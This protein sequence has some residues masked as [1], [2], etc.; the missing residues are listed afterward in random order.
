MGAEQSTPVNE[1][2]SVGSDALTTRALVICGPSGV[3][4]GKKG[5]AAAMCGKARC[6]HR[7][8]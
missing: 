5:C 6:A 8:T 4:K 2:A 3:G 1:A 7:T